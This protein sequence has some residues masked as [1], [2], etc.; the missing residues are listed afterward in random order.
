MVIMGV[1]PGTAITGYGVVQRESATKF[2][3]LGYGAIVT[4]SELPMEQRLG[5]IYAEM[6][7]LIEE[8]RPQCLAVEQL[9]FNTNVTTALTV[10]QARG[11]VLLAGAHSNLEVAEYTP[12]QVKQAVTGQGRATKEQVGYMVRML[13]GLREVPRPDDVADA[14]AIGLCHGYN[15]RK[16]SD[17]HD[18]NT[19]W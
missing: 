2:T 1:D 14:L 4:P 15:C 11:V 19:V 5:R 17:G 10:G 9:F 13:L 7:R 6:M 12:L 16:W 8:Y 3:V 18:R